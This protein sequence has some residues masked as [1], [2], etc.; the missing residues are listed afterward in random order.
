MKT[1]CEKR[2][3]K[4]EYFV[5]MN[6]VEESAWRAFIHVSND[7]YIKPEHEAF[8]RIMGTWV[9]KMAAK[10]GEIKS[11]EAIELSKANNQGATI[12]EGPSFIFELKVRLNDPRR[13]GGAVRQQ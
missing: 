8:Q 5:I 6:V 12:S 1:F 13:F 9:G 4:P 11:I 3:F 7:G 10:I 2:A